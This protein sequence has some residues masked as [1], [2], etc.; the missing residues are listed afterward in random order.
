[1]TVRMITRA[2]LAPLVLFGGL[3]F[4]IPTAHA[5]DQAECTPAYEGSLTFAA[6]PT[7]AQPGETV[8][9]SGEGWPPN[10]LVPL[11]FNGQSIGDAETDDSGSFTFDY[12]IPAGTSAGEQEFAATCDEAVVLTQTI[13]IVTAATTTVTPAQLPATGSDSAPLVQIG[14][15]LIVV[16]GLAAFLAARRRRSA[17]AT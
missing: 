11:T 6:D 10:S 2:L 8:T 13:Q 17:E 1:M 5:Q 7:V 12:V 3:M 15:V 4:V 9:L 14:L 16:G